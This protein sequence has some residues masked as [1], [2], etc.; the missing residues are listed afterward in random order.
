MNKK[1]RVFPHRSVPGKNVGV[2]FIRGFPV[3]TSRLSR[4]FHFG[5]FLNAHSARV[6]TATAAAIAATTTTTITT[7][8]VAATTAVATTL[9]AVNSQLNPIKVEK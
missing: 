8:A 9:T 4:T 5:A 2:V 1:T 3:E 7:T 6:A